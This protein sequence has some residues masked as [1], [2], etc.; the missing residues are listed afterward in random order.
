MYSDLRSLMCTNVSTCPQ[1]D[2]RIALKKAGAKKIEYTKQKV[3]IDTGCSLECCTHAGSGY[4]GL[5]VCLCYSVASRAKNILNMP[6]MGTNF[7][8]QAW[9]GRSVGLMGPFLRGMSRSQ[10]PSV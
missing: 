6:P 10:Y 2:N 9:G 1:E 8:L 4:C 3:V 5:P 7:S